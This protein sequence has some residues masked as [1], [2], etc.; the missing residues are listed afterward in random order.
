MKVRWIHSIVNEAAP[1]CGFD[2]GRQQPG[3]RV[4]GWR[5]RVASI[6]VGTA[7]SG[8]RIRS[9]QVTISTVREHK[10]RV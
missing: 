6:T 2:Y 8:Q 5:R 10:G 1:N 7:V 4:C 9:R 3:A